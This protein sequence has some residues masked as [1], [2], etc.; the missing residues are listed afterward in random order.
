LQGYAEG[1][2]GIIKQFSQQAAQQ[3]EN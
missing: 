3:T 1:E 2:F